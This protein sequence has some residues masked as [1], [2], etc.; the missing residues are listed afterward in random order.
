MNFDSPKLDLRGAGDKDSLFHMSDASK[1]AVNIDGIDCKNYRG[2]NHQE[3]PPQF[4]TDH[5]D[6]YPDDI[7][8]L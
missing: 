6:G 1:S 3:A 8:R 4:V 2:A 5:H 7:A